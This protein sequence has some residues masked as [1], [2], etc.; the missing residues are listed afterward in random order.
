MWEEDVAL[1]LEIM[2]R[3]TYLHVYPQKD[4]GI[5][6]RAFDLGFKVLGL[7]HG[8]ATVSRIMASS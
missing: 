6:Q 7:D 4:L 5:G 3:A 8:L 1:T 2:T